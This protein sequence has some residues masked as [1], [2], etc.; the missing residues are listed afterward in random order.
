MGEE[1]NTQLVTTSFLVVL[2]SYEVSPEPKSFYCHVFL[3]QGMS[4]QSNL[5][6]KLLGFLFKQA[7]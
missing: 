6:E 7:K 3:L 2:E 1:A 5:K 4:H